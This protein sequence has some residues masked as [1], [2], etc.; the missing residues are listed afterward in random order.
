MEKI[1]IK[2]IA[3]Q[4]GITKD[5]A[6]RLVKKQ[7]KEL[8]ITPHYGKRREMFLSRVDAERLIS[9]YEPR[10]L[11]SAST[12]GATNI[13]GFGYFYIIQLHPED[14]PNRFKIGYSDKLDVRQSDHRTIAPTLKLVKFWPCKRTWENAA[15]ASITRDGCT[16]IGGE[17]YDGNVQ[18]LIDHSEAFFSV[19]PQPTTL[20]EDSLE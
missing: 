12:N 18:V 7:K 17:V 2:E 9:S 6:L 19:M 3:E 8:G 20:S 1:P 10:R 4:L 11:R 16:Y 13:E 14:I 5:Y 15:R